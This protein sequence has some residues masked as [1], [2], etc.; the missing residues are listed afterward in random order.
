MMFMGLD[1]INEFLSFRVQTSALIQ[2]RY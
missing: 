1:S 2:V